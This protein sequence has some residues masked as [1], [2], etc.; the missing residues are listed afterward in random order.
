[1]Q[2]EKP[3]SEKLEDLVEKAKAGD[4]SA[5]EGVVCACQDRV[6]H[7]AMRI[8]VNPDDAAE[9]SQEILIRIVTKLS[10]F[11][12]RSGFQTW[13]YRVAVNYLLNA[14]KIRDRDM[15][16]NFEAFA[17]DLHDGLV[18]DP[19][20]SG[21]DALALSELRVSCTMAMLLCLDINHRVAYV[22]GDVLEL[23]HVEA[24][25]ILSISKD[26]YRQRLSRARK[27]VVAFTSAQCGL[28]NEAAACSCPKRLPAAVAKGRVSKTMRVFSDE[29]GP[30]YDEVLTKA[31]GVEGAL[32][33][34]I[35]QRSTPHYPSPEDLGGKLAEIVSAA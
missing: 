25:E 6:H 3:M 30:S 16:L 21:E 31:R 11:D 35:L 33:T 2:V 26:A 10:T 22:L 19:A 15:G 32:R 34:L 24:S 9:A 1:M 14:K 12:G 28:A 7:L 29:G 5:L 4:R 27:E 17:E 20:P 13:A 18:A 23:D 8:L